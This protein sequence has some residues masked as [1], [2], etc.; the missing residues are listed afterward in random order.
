MFFVADY[1]AVCA[2]M[3]TS[4]F[5][6][7]ASSLSPSLT[8]FPSVPRIPR[9]FPLGGW[10]FSFPL[11]VS[12]YLDPSIFSL[13]CRRG[14]QTLLLPQPLA[15][16]SSRTREEATKLV[17]FLTVNFFLY[18]WDFGTPSL[19]RQLFALYFFLYF[20]VLYVSLPLS[21]S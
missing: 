13:P 3:T 4:L 10:I 17:L 21:G 7:P 11:S 12:F 9:R 16:T 20:V 8:V 18:M 2:I 19:F 5:L 14:G 15:T 1:D 6:S